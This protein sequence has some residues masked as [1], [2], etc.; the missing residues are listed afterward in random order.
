M[1]K[2]L[3]VFLCASFLLTGCAT[4]GREMYQSDINKVQKGVTT[5][6][7][8]IDIFGNPNTTFLD[9]NG[10]TVFNYI[11][12]KCQNTIYNFIPVINIVHSE[13]KMQ[14]Q[15]LSI[16]FDKDDKVINY[17]FSDSATPI[18]YGISP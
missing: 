9:A 16:I 15:M 3:L 6:Q 18:K 17:S 4:V 13:M 7:Q 1:H 11:A 14:N 5:K 8:I 10:N 12:A 2:T